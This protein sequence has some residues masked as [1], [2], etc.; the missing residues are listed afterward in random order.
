MN[1][2]R[3]RAGRRQFL[4]VAAVFFGPLVLAAWLYY[5]AALR[6]GTVSNHGALLE[7][8]VNLKDELPQ[9]ALLEDPRWQLVYVNAGPCDEPCR[10]ALY[11]LRQSRLMLGKDMD[12]LRRVFLHGDS[13]P[14]TLFLADEHEGLITL[15]DA[16]L[17]AILDD[18]KPGH[19]AAGGYY[20]IDPHGNLVLYFAP[21]TNPRDMV[22]DIEHLLDLSRIG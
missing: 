7:P 21:G 14:D 4:L 16:G 19:L 15:Q 10:E 1:D 8:I 22:D 12:R 5:G 9:L 2:A 17:R 13:A 3:R 6:P 11:T 18:R 20:L